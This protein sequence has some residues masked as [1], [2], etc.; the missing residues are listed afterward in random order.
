MISIIRHLW[1]HGSAVTEY[2]AKSP[3]KTAGEKL[4]EA[5]RGRLDEMIDADRREIAGDKQNGLKNVKA[6]NEY[7]GG[8]VLDMLLSYLFQLPKDEREKY[9]HILVS[10]LG[11]KIERLK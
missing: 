6:R 1:G 10:E 11:Y 7:A 8:L 9:R 5:A 3:E 2:P 4:A